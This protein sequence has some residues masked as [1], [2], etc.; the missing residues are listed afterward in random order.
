MIQLSVQ[1][2]GVAAGVE[3]EGVRP[4]GKPENAARARRAA[5]TKGTR[6]ATQQDVGQFLGGAQLASAPGVL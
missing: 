5:F 1:L 2:T 4:P 3:Y 6:G